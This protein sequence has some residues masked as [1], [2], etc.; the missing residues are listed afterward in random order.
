MRVSIVATALDGHKTQ[1]NTVL[2]MVSRIQNRNSGYSDNLFSNSATTENN[3]FNSIEG[4]T[5][6]K[7]D[8]KFEVN[9]Q[10][11]MITENI[12]QN[13]NISENEMTMNEIDANNIPNGVSMESA[14]YIESKKENSLH[15]N[16]ASA[17]VNLAQDSDIEHTPQLFENEHETKVEN[18]LEEDH[19]S[20]SEKLFDQDTND[21]DEDFEIPAFLR[22]QKF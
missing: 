13:Q 17:N 19:D 16:D 9:E 10:E 22:K 8:E 21:E 18:S 3:T 1:T 4:A 2:N 15:D 14:T 6:L 7:L 12:E 20:Y 11:Q 5:A